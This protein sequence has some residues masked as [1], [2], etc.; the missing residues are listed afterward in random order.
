M[1]AAPLILVYG[2]LDNDGGKYEEQW[3]WIRT[4]RRLNNAADFINPTGNAKDCNKKINPASPTIC[5]IDWYNA[6]KSQGANIQIWFY[7]YTGHGM[8]QHGPVKDLMT[9]GTGIQAYGNT[10]APFAVQK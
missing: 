5:P 6:Q 9:K 1:L 2:K 4:T 10:G 8:F 3:Q 7:E